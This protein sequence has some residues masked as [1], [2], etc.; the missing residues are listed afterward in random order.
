MLNVDVY[1][2]KKLLCTRISQQLLQPLTDIFG[3]LLVRSL[4]CGE[5][6]QLE[7]EYAI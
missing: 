6:S 1:G 4:V 7:V 2:Y 3:S 5:N